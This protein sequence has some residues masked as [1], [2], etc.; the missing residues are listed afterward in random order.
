M[1]SAANRQIL[2]L[3]LLSAMLFLP[4]LGMRDFWAPDEPRYAEVV[5]EMLMEGDYLVLRDNGKLYPDKPPLYFWMAGLSATLLGGVSEFTLRLPAALAGM[6]VVLLCFF[7]GRELFSARAGFLGACILA[8]TYGFF[9]ESNWVH[10]DTTLTLWVT[11]ALYCFWKGA[12]QPHPSMGWM[13]GFYLCL[14]LGLLTKGPVG[15]VLPLA[16]A[17][18]YFLWQGKSRMWV[19]WGLWWGLPAAAGMAVAWGVAAY[20]SSSGEY[21]L[22][23]VLS[24]HVLNRVTRGLHHLRGPGYYFLHLPVNFL[25]W[26][27]FFPAVLIGAFVA[28]YRPGR[29][30]VRFCLSWVGSMFLVFTLSAEKRGIY[31]LPLLPALAMLFGWFWD[32][33]LDTV[34]AR[35]R[36]DRVVML[37]LVIWGTLLLSLSWVP[38]RYGVGYPDLGSTPLALSVVL[39]ILGLVHLGVGFRGGVRI[40]FGTMWA[41]AA[42]LLW[43]FSL[44]MAPALNRYKSARP[45]CNRVRS[46]AED[47]PLCFFGQYRST[48][49]Y[50]TGRFLEE[51]V[52]ADELTGF[53]GRSEPVF[54]LVAEK[55]L[56]GLP[57]SLRDV[58]HEW[59]RQG[60]GHLI[61]LLISN[62]AVETRDRQSLMIPPEIGEFP[63]H[64]KDH[65]E[66]VAGRRAGTARQVG[67]RHFPY[68]ESLAVRLVENLRVDKDSIGV[69]DQ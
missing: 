39:L 52:T 5:R 66:T 55:E 44:I 27:V 64:P 51:I 18:V 62:R 69:Q 65:V 49:V 19:R 8:T 57:S 61:M 38:Y 42:C 7:F 47:H 21:N 16:A 32:R 22:S 30:E 40:G 36:P 11:L 4:A 28:A 48:Y 58:I 24:T 17:A 25:P 63:E 9:S 35:S 3:V 12:R 34:A 59:D 54:C 41:G 26:S 23:E 13:V 60:V 43:F 56:R 29:P 33:R 6:A 50:Y 68:G 10:L 20:L 45:F 2:I 46:V 14:G 67:D 31:M 1:P 53:L 37:P 15:L